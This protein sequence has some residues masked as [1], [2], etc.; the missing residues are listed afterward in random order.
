MTQEKILTRL[1]KVQNYAARLVKRL[2]RRASIQPVLQDLHW[3]PVNARINYKVA[4]YV[5]QCI[6]ESSF[7]S[8]LKELLCAYTPTRTLRSSDKNLLQKSSPKLKQYGERAFSFAG[9]DVWNSLP[10]LVKSSPSVDI[11]KKRLKTH[12]FRTCYMTV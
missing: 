3:L 6:N 12:L 11:L 5:Y 2:P 8:Y 9:A 7:P 1:Q 4:L 10:T